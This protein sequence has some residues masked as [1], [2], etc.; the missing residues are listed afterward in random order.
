MTTHTG[1]F[2]H[3]FY[4]KT[5]YCFLFIR[6]HICISFSLKPTLNVCGCV[7]HKTYMDTMLVYINHNFATTIINLSG[8]EFTLEESTRLLYTC[9]TT[10]RNKWGCRILQKYLNYVSELFSGGFCYFRALENSNSLPRAKNSL[11]KGLIKIALFF[12]FFH[13]HHV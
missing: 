7:W 12:L 3:L 5:K 1:S 11:P 9:A 13:F 2:I 6:E 10:W 4:M 8:C